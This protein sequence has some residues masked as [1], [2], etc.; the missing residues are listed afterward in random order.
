M[1]KIIRTNRLNRLMDPIPVSLEA[2]EAQ[3]PGMCR[4]AETR[5]TPSTKGRKRIDF[6]EWSVL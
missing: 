3:C 6:L 5:E 1:Q 2:Q 4:V